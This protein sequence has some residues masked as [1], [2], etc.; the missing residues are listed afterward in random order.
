MSIL[1]SDVRQA[2]ATDAV[3]RSSVAAMMFLLYDICLT[4]DDE[5][6]LIWPKPWSFTK[7]LFFF[8]RYF[9]VVTQFSILFVASDYEFSQHECFVWEIWQ[10]T[11]AVALV[12]SVDA[13]LI[14]R[15]RALYGSTKFIPYAL[16]ALYLTEIVGMS[17]SLAI[18]LPGMRFN[19]ICLTTY[20]P[21]SILGYLYVSDT[22]NILGLSSFRHLSRSDGFRFVRGSSILFQGILFTLTIYQFAIGLRDEWGR[23]RV[24]DLIMRDGT[25]G[26][27]LVFAINLL[28]ASIYLL[29]NHAYAGLFYA[30]S[31]TTFSFTGYR[32]VIN[33]QH[34]SPQFP[35]TTLS[36]VTDT[37]L[38]FSAVL[39]TDPSSESDP[40]FPATVDIEMAPRSGQG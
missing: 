10:C 22:R 33:L 9:P 31:L 15:V 8:V 24:V 20:I 36:H 30:W 28:Q 12:V 32:I 2:E 6:N 11:A 38:D 29:K 40:P 26:F 4:F 7:F 39:N 14:M 17:T 16:L 21:K 25:W 27:V 3:N 19:D 13:I 18:S 5:V 23:S 34:L 37:R 35:S 1:S